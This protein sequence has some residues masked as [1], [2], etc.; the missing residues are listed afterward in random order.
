MAAT[1][2][3]L[4]AAELTHSS[5]VLVMT[6]LLVAAEPTSL[7]AATVSTPTPLKASALVLQL[8]LMLTEPVQLLMVRL[9]RLS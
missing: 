4:V 1:T 3:L 8:R 6:S 5:A 7:M 2:H 9:M